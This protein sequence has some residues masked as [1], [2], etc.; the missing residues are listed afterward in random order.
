VCAVRERASSSAAAFVETKTSTW[1]V[2]VG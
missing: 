1:G 2:I